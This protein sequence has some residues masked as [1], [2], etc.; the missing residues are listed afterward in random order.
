MTRLLQTR[1][2]T[3]HLLPVGLCCF[4]PVF[5]RM[6]ASQ[7]LDVAVCAEQSYKSELHLRLIY[8]TA[9]INDRRKVTRQ[10]KTHGFAGVHPHKYT[11]R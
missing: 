8:S 2:H 4:Q 5:Q 1:Q 9:L 6:V 7:R 11:Y 10:M 3:L